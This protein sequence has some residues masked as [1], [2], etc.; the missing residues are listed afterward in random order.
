[1]SAAASTIQR[2]YMRH[3]IVFSL[4]DQRCS[5]GKGG[6]PADYGSSTFDAEFDR[7]VHHCRRYDD[8]DD[9]RSYMELTWKLKR[10]EVLIS[11]TGGAQDFSLASFATRV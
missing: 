10:P 8:C 5:R 2:L 9:A 1:M 7:A 4:F 3:R 11:V 6:D